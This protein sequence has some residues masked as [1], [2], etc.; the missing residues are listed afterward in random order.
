M[1]ALQ[2]D[3]DAEHRQQCKVHREGTTIEPRSCYQQRNEKYQFPTRYKAR[4]SLS[5]SPFLFLLSSSIR[6][7]ASSKPCTSPHPNSTTSTTK[8]TTLSSAK[9][10]RPQTTNTTTQPLEM[11]PR[12]IFINLPVVDVR[13]STTFYESIGGSINPNFTTPECTCMVFSESIYVMIMTPEMFK[14]NDIL[15]SPLTSLQRRSLSPVAEMKKSAQWL[16][17]TRIL[18]TAQGNSRCA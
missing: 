7:P 6:V 4:S 1:A 3:E 16:T 12:M 14:G 10:H 2:L 17:I 18:P 15:S 8:V 9:H 13:A 11:A 5:T